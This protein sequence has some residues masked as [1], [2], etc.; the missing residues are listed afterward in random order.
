M[1]GVR[2]L[3]GSL[4]KILQAPLSFY[5]SQK[6]LPL[7]VKHPRPKDSLY[8]ILGS[9]LQDADRKLPAKLAD[10]FS[11]KNLHDKIMDSIYLQQ[12]LVFMYKHYKWYH[13]FPIAPPNNSE[14]MTP[15]FL[16]FHERGF[17]LYKL[18]SFV[19]PPDLD[20]AVHSGSEEI[21]MFLDSY[22]L[23]AQFIPII[24]MIVNDFDN[25]DIGHPNIGYDTFSYFTKEDE[26]ER[27]YLME[28]G[29]RMKEV[30]KRG[31]TDFFV[32]EHA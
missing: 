7:Y 24:K 20:Y 21:S 14:M 30:V 11:E 16:E 26:S 22:H 4:D 23:K 19:F 6:G 3:F 13:R 12:E 17:L 9:N 27:L 29:D 31:Y 25:L 8:S 2:Y 28:F 10:I 5:F 32:F 18:F 1:N 15:F